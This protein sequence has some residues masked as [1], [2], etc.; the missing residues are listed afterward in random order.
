MAIRSTMAVLTAE[1]SRNPNTTLT[2]Q[3]G[4]DARRSDPSACRQTSGPCSAACNRARPDGPAHR[5]PGL[6]GS[7]ALMVKLGRA[8]MARL[9]RAVKMQTSNMTQRMAGRGRFGNIRIGVGGA[10]IELHHAGG[11]GDGLHAGQRQHHADK[12][13]PILEEPA[14]QRLH[15]MHR[16]RQGAAGKKSPAAARPPPS[17]PKPERQTR[18][19]ARGPKMLSNPMMTMA[20]AA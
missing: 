15:V 10:R 1:S 18:R 13:F 6:A 2:M 7:V 3:P 19:C 12:A 11:I 5:H 16:R 8:C 4:D 9:S 17:A 20:P 14:G